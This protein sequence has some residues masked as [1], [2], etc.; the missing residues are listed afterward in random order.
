MS[1]FNHKM[2]KNAWNEHVMDQMDTGWCYIISREMIKVGLCKVLWVPW[3]VCNVRAAGLS[4][5]FY[6]GFFNNSK[7]Y[8]IKILGLMDFHQQQKNFNFLL[9]SRPWNRQL[10]QFESFLVQHNQHTFFKLLQ[11][12]ALWVP[13]YSME[14]RKTMSKYR[15]LGIKANEAPTYPLLQGNECT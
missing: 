14:I 5:A 3:S 15:Q 2:C 13:F 6:K 8:Y 9:G 12:R 1:Y 7:L 11:S 10:L 4:F